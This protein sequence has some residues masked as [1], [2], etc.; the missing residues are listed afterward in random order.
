MKKTF[1]LMIAVF[2][3]VVA[4]TSCEKEGQYKPKKKISQI[5]YT[6]SHKVGDLTISTKKSEKWTWGGAVLSYIDFY[7]SDDE[8]TNTLLFRYDDDYRIKE[9][10]DSQYSV[11]YDYDNGH[12]DEIEIRDRNTGNLYRKLEFGYKGSKLATIDVTTNNSKASAPMMFNPLRFM[13]PDDVAEMMMS[14]AASKGVVHYN[15]T[16]SGKNIAEIVSDGSERTYVK[17]SYD[18]MINPLKGFLNTNLGLDESYSAN[19]AVRE[20]IYADGKTTIV[21]YSYE[22]NGKYPTKVKYQ[23]ES[24]LLVP[25]VTLTVDNVITYQY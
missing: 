4:F 19:N 18:N 24:S 11:E 10:E 1:A 16:W 5:I 3:M 17:W 21:D 25:G 22:Y 15:I 23:T 2:A 8:R 6:Q 13:L 9:L 14:N 12:L 20:E 7:G